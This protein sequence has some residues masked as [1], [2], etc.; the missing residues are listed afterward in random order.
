M[1]K[2]SRRIAIVG[3]GPSAV[4]IVRNLLQ[5]AGRF[6]I[7]VFEAG[8]AVGSGIP[9]AE[10]QNGPQMMANITSVEIPPVLVSL[11]DWL[12]AGDGDVLRRFG[13]KRDDIGERD[14]YPRILIGA[15]YVD[16]LNRLKQAGEVAGH[17][18]ILEAGV[19][20][21]DIEP[22]PDGF[23][24]TVQQNGRTARQAFDAVFMATGH[25]TEMKKPKRVSGLYRSPY[26]T[27]AL[28]LGPDR[29]ALVLGSSLSAIDAV[30]ALATR[31]GSF[32]GDG[33][34]VDYVARSDR[35]LRLVMA[36]RK[37]I[38]PEADFYY[39]IPEEPLFIFSP[40]RLAAM[41]AEGRSGLL[42]RAMALFRQQLVADDPEFV[43]R[44]GITRFTPEN[45]A[46]AYFNLRQARHGF[47]PVSA[48]LAEAKANHGRKHVV[49][50][51]YTLMRAHEAFSGIVPFLD[52][53]DLKR[54]RAHMAPVFSDAYGCVPHISIER[55]LALHRAGCLEIVALGDG[56]SI[57]YGKGRF[58]LAGCGRD[59]DFGVLIDARGQ[60]AE[61]MA[62]LGFAKLDQALERT[63]F[64]RRSG[65]GGEEDQFRLPLDPPLSRDIFCLSIPLMMHRYPFAQGL[66][67]C[68]EAA[69][70]AA[71]AL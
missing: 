54:F 32:R 45:F 65:A 63:D 44:L 8:Q 57:R 62:S 68:A 39:P 49:M 2:A 18:V 27:Q 50:W 5:K 59:Q 22:R 20:V 55:L 6:H 21:H 53:D 58:A 40:A 33:D 46:R 7:T 34:V 38:L 13:L 25:L 48:N 11:A 51:R 23:A 15:Y 67:A 35:P 16:Q 37:G 66:V 69:E 14:F 17:R 29:A 71:G 30:I 42:S 10:D 3:G 19:S 52:R 31:Y 26:P 60:Q 64:F 47:S 1:P 56:G 9:Y 70:V 24:L 41:T 61:T 43:E 12:R 4:Y 36:S 28:E